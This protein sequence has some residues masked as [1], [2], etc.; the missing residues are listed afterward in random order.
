MGEP[1]GQQQV[2]EALEE[3]E[4]WKHEDDKLKKQFKFDDFRQAVTFIVRL[5]F[6]AEDIMHH[7]EIFNVYNTVDIALTTHDAGG[8]VTEKDVNLAQ[9]LDSLYN[10]L[11]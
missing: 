7:P 10:S 3:L 9:T 2:N 5:S 1:L 6:E 11:N 4:G 8:K